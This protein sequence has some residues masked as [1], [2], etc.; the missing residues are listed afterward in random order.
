M[1]KLE[2]L[3][4]LPVKNFAIDP[5]VQGPERPVGKNREHV[6]RSKVKAA[7]APVGNAG[8]YDLYGAIRHTGSLTNG[9]YTA[10]CKSR[11]PTEGGG[12]RS[13][14][15]EL[16]DSGS[17]KLPVEKVVDNSAYVCFYAKMVPSKNNASVR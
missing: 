12:F 5:F 4:S 2:E 15:H 11:T 9:H 10:I 8:G 7:E 1:S 14:W 13:Q 3:V 17:S 16:N 6:A